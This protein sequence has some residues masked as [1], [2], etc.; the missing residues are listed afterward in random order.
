[1]TTKC[2]KTAFF[3]DF[4]RKYGLRGFLYFFF[5]KIS[6]FLIDICV[7]IPIFCAYI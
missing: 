4:E 5:K 7:K 3:D 2:R 1:M 6:D